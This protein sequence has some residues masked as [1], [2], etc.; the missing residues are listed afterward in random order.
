MGQAIQTLLALSSPM[1]LLIFCKT[2]FLYPSSLNDVLLSWLQSCCCLFYPIRSSWVTLS[3]SPSSLLI[4]PLR[5]AKPPFSELKPSLQPLMPIGHLCSDAPL[6]LKR[7]LPLCSLSQEGGATPTHCSNQAHASPHFTGGKA[8]VQRG[9]DAR[10]GHAH[11]SRV[12]RRIRTLSCMD[13]RVS[14]TGHCTGG[15][16]YKTM[17][18]VKCFFQ[19]HLQL[20]RE[21][22]KRYGTTDLRKRREA[23]HSSSIMGFSLGPRRGHGR[24]RS[25]GSQKERRTLSERARG[26][27]T[28]QGAYLFF[29][30]SF[31][32]HCRALK[33]KG[34]IKTC[35]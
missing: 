31:S 13:L 22:T 21:S 27:G 24:N 32:S 11:S 28:R 16:T 26:T 34:I 20:R 25:G 1:S 8:G 12:K 10:S 29:V 19:P 30:A 3:A 2:L 17:L 33:H 7:R 15:C 6:S 5:F 9:R 4:L 18:P 23:E 14:I 35:I